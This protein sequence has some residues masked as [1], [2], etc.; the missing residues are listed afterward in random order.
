MFEEKSIRRV[1]DVAE[2]ADVLLYS[3]GVP[4]ADSYIYRAGYIERP[5]LDE[6][7]SDGVVGDI[8]TVFFR[9]DGSYAD[10]GMNAR[11]SGP[12]LATLSSHK[13]TICIVAGH[14]KREAIPGALRGGFMNTLIIDEPTARSLMA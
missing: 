1:V 2:Q 5:E 13:D 7:L 9:G 8:A 4:N 6:L 11:S 3:I 14:R 10:I 12:D